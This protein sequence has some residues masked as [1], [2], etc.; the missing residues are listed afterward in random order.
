MWAVARASVCDRVARVKSSNRSRS[1]TVR[2][3]RP[4]ARI[5]RVDPV[6]QPHQDRVD[7]S[8]ESARPPEG[9]L[10][11]DRPPPPARPRP[12]AGRGC[13][14][15]HAGAGPTPGRASRP[16][17]PRGSAATSPTVRDARGRA[18]C[19]AVTGPTPQSRSTGSGCRNASSRVGRHHQQAVR[20]GHP[21]GHLGQE[22]GAGDPDRDRQ[23][24]PGRAPRAAAARDLRRRARRSAAGRRRRGTPRRSTSPR[25]AASC[26]SKTS[27]TALLA[28]A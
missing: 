12:A 24:R 15:A 11:A 17:P 21:A 28:S 1:M 7:S 14:P 10:G 27:N 8:G 3:T 20:L 16:A 18:A 9:P 6:D 5:R 26:R 25:P 4:A 23:A 19:S 13:G 2:P 22:L